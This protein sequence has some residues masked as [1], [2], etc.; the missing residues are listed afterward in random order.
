MPDLENFIEKR[1][2]DPSET[3]PKSKKSFSW[4]RSWRSFMDWKS[5][6]KNI[7]WKDITSFI[8]AIS[9]VALFIFLALHGV[10]MVDGFH[11]AG[12]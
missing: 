8:F 3:L 12:G 6:R 1:P 4:A 5:W 2:L 7:V 10:A 11:L 9:F